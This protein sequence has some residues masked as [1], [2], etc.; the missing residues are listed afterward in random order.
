MSF[1]ILVDHKVKLKECGKKNKDLNF[2]RVLK[3]IWN[4]KVTVIPMVIGTLGTIPKGLLKGNK[5]TS[6]NHP[7]YCIIKIGLKT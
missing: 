3:K 2:I 4:M 1:V 7:D 5:R 6:G